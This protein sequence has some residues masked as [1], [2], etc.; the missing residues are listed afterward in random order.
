M[1]VSSFSPPAAT[2]SH[3]AKALAGKDLTAQPDS[4]I[5]LHARAVES[6]D[7]PWVLD[8]IRYHWAGEPVI[9]NST[10]YDPNLLAGLIAMRDGQR[11]GLITYAIEAGYCEVVT[12]NALERHRSIGTLLIEAVCTIAKQAGCTRIGQVTTNDNLGAL[13]FYQRRGFRIVAIRPGAVDVSRGSK[14]SI[15]LLGNDGIPLR[16]EIQLERAI[17][18]KG[19]GFLGILHGMVLPV[20][21]LP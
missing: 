11:V 13:R 5:P 19:P 21:D 18:A 15:P 6:S 1:T 14:P 17:D 3:L 7:R 16:D 10:W 12:L 4:K 2:Q 8:L 20:R 9:V